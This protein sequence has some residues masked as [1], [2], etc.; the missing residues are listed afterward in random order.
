MVMLSRNGDESMTSG[1]AMGGR[2]RLNG[3]SCSRARRYGR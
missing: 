2:T 3:Q 1:P